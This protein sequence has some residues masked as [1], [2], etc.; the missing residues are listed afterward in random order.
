MDDYTTKELGQILKKMYDDAENRE[1]V[2]KIHMFGIEYGQFITLNNVR[3]SEIASN[4]GLNPS[5]ATEIR[6][7]IRI[8][9]ELLKSDV[10]KTNI[11]SKIS[12][13]DSSSDDNSSF[14]FVGAKWNETDMTE[15]FVNNG[16]WENGYN[17]RYIGKVNS[18][19][20]GDKIAIKAAYTRQSNL[21]FDPRGNDVACMSIKAIGEVTK[22]HN[23][24]KR[25]DVKWQVVSPIKEW[26]FFTYRQTIW[27]VKP[28]DGWMHQ[29]LID[30]TFNNASQDITRFR[31]EPFWAERFG[32]E[33]DNDSEPIDE[34][35]YPLYTK[36]DF[37]LDVYITAKKYDDIV[38]LLD[39]KQ[40][41]IL[42]G[43]PGVGKSFMA[44]RLAYSIMGVKDER[45]IEMIQFH[46]NYS[47]E[48][49]IE[50]FRPN[51]SGGFRLMK[52]IFRDFCERA[53]NDKSN[54]Y[55][56]IIDEI[57]RGNLSK[58][59][60]ELMFLLENDKRGEDFAMKLTY[61][62]K[63]FYVP[64]NIYVIGMMN[65]A[66]RSLAMIDYA[67][68]RRFSFVHME[69]AFNDDGFISSFREMYLDADTV[70]D[71]ML[72]LNAFI[73]KELDSGHQIGHSYFCSNEPLSDNDIAGIFKYEI[74]ELLQEYFFDNSSNLEETL[75]LINIYE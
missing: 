18:I 59:M 55:F 15:T 30:F 53:Q 3:I 43:A 72:K 32:D 50:G 10:G 23:N 6:K 41:I 13:Y 47:Y 58:V 45:K 75:K 71:K 25:V 67:L 16:Y 64:E 1:K 51:E 49:F 5:Y 54:K 14:W 29:A 21:P 12:N 26:H 33:F 57:N 65:T 37:L 19:K 24:G 38:A 42:Q 74:K 39:R 36:D 11:I 2:R 61:S 62:G 28:A 48:D 34:I 66:D 27:E 69:P 22:N 70:I 73:S 56:F 60:G 17:D 8:G 44:K 7:G 35:E 9:A 31:N 40:N 46:Q 4:A 52:G 20:V 68:R 63:K